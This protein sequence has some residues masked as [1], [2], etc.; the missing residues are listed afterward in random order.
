MLLQNKI[1]GYGGEYKGCMAPM[2]DISKI[3]FNA[4]YYWLKN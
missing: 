1:R 2:K 3:Q 4:S